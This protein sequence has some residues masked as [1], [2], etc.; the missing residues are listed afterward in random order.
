MTS[1]RASGRIPARRSASARGNSGSSA[2]QGEQHGTVEAG[3]PRRGVEG[4]RLVDRHREAAEVLEHLG[5][6]EHGSHPAAR[7]VVDVVVG[8]RAVAGGRAP[9]A[10]AAQRGEGGPEP[11]RDLGDR[12]QGLE[13]GRR[14]VLER[15]AVREHERPEA[16]G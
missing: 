5:L 11:A 15:V 7:E 2:P 3:Q 1:R 13:R 4:D 6:L 10:G 16:V 12:D 14:E 9:H 8:E